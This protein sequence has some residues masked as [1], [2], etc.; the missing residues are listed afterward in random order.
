[1]TGIYARRSWAVHRMRSIATLATML[2]AIAVGSLVGA[3]VLANRLNNRTANTL[4]PEFS[5]VQLDGTVL[6]SSELTG[7][8]V[9][10]DFWATWCPPCRQEFPQL[11]K[12]YRRYRA[13]S[14]VRFLAIDVNREDETPEK[15]VLSLERRGTA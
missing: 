5:V 3:P 2:S 13:N 1:V 10:L 8:V 12:L 6:K 4:V 11:E 15:P 7:R 9:V 14:D